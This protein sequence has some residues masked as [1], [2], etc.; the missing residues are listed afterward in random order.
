MLSVL[1]FPASF[2]IV[3]ATA[4]LLL[5]S[6]LFAQSTDV[7]GKGPQSGTTSSNSE[8]ATA[9]EMLQL[10]IYQEETAG[11]LATAKKMYRRVVEKA[12]ESAKLAAEAQYR[13][14]QCLLKEGDQDAATAAFDALIKEFPNQTDWVKKANE[15][16]GK[17]L[18]LLPAPYQSGQRQ[19]LTMTLAGGQV[20]GFIGVGVDSGEFEGKSVWRMFVRRMINPT[21][22]EG[23]STMVIDAA[24]FKP[25]K[26]TFQH[27]LLGDSSAIWTDG[28]LDIKMRDASGN[29]QTKTIELTTDAYCN[30]QW[31]FGFRQLPLRIGYKATLPIRV[32][33]TG[34][35][36]IGLE[37]SVEKKETVETFVGKFECFRVDTNIG[38]VFWIADSPERLLV[39]FDG[40]GVVAKLSDVRADGAEE[41]LKNAHYGFQCRLPQ[42]WFSMPMPTDQEDE[43][44]GFLMASTGMA[45]SMIRVQKQS[46]LAED[47]QP[48]AD[49]WMK[50]RLQKAAKALKDFAPVGDIAPATI[51][52]APAVSASATFVSGPYTMKRTTTFAFIGDNAV[53]VHHTTLADEFEAAAATFHAITSSVQ[54]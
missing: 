42:G 27:T 29:S 9:A 24:T 19:T 30:D 48:S 43:S 40:G 1:N 52:D 51:G 22:N 3:V 35:N 11:D 53:E 26:T 4:S 37:V 6:D 34:G 18:T 5:T 46:S 54:F 31:F 50:L 39:A 17:A 38:Q 21:M 47:A 36:E 15:M 28:E 49:A 13:L 2:R 7:G 45:S 32:A 12:K 23:A 44:N 8:T 14:G 41:V 33:F 16:V 20:I 10:G 25:L